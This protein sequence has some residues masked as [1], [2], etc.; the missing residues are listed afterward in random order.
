MR[1]SASRLS[2]FSS[3]DS[4]WNRMPDQI[5]VS[6]FIA[7]TTEDYNS[8]TTSSFTTRLHNCRNTVT[9]LEEK[10]WC[11]T[12]SLCESPDGQM[13]LNLKV[14]HT[15]RDHVVPSYNGAVEWA[16]G[17]RAT[18]LLSPVSAVPEFSLPSTIRSMHF[19]GKLTTLWKV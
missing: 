17:A 4:L 11:W 1:S 15:R 6:E 14:S 3:R 13:E 12:M 8:P 9:L 19:C 18:S 16:A 2:S 10:L 5:S 7:E